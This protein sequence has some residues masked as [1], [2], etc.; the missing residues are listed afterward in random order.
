MCFGLNAEFPNDFGYRTGTSKVRV[1]TWYGP[2]GI[3]RGMMVRPQGL[4]VRQ[5]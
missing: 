1:E 3:L 4:F 5:H 2:V